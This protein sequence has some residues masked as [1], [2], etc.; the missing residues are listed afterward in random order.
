M[1]KTA[2]LPDGGFTLSAKRT[3]RHFV[4][5]NFIRNAVGRNSTVTVG[6]AHLVS[7]LKGQTSRIGLTVLEQKVLIAFGTDRNPR[8]ILHTKRLSESCSR[9]QTA[10]CCAG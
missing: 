4:C 1:Y 8:T 9:F 5:L 10:F 7:A 6:Y 2:V 3:R